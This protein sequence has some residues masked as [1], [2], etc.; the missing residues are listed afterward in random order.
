M[1]PPNDSGILLPDHH[2]DPGHELQGECA[3]PRG[4][5]VQQQ[6]LVRARRYH[7]LVPRLDQKRRP[8]LSDRKV[9]AIPSREVL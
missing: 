5:P 3:G 6:F 9:R 8:R 2:A 7:H 1:C 4:L